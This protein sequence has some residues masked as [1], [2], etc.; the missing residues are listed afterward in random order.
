MNDL[1]V[2]SGTGNTLSNVSL[3]EVCDVPNLIRCDIDNAFVHV[4]RAEVKNGGVIEDML[5]R[6]RIPM[7]ANNGDEAKKPTQGGERTAWKIAGV[8]IAGCAY[9]AKYYF[10]H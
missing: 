6:A 5:R 8:V 3:L 4:K 9:A 10:F 7:G 1:Q 2:L